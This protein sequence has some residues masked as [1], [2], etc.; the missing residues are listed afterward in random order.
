MKG[1]TV[2]TLYTGTVGGKPVRFFRSPFHPTPDLPWCDWREVLRA[3]GTSNS[4]A[5]AMTRDLQRDWPK[6]ARTVAA[7]GGL[8]V[9][10]PFHAAANLAEAMP[11]PRDRL[12]QFMEAGESALGIATVHLPTALAR[13]DWAVQA[14]LLDHFTGSNRPAGDGPGGAA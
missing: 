11:G 9:A 6:L 10:V 1:T 2:Y 3:L 7:D 8:I 14:A 13:A 5:D 4:Q 12:R